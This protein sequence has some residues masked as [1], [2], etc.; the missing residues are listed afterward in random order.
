MK[1][2]K[3]IK[4]LLPTSIVVLTVLIVVA[5]MGNPPQ[6]KRSPKAA[7][8]KVLVE[9]QKIET[10]P[11]TVVIESY[12]TVKPRTKSTLTSQ[13]SGQI[14]YV[15][16]NFREG[17]FFKKGEVLIELDNRD[18]K[19]G[20]KVAEAALIL[21]QQT[22]SEESAKA[23]QAR[24]NWARL[25]KKG[26][27][28]D[29]VLRIP[30]LEAAKASV[31]SLEAQLSIAKLSLER[32]QIKTPFAG[33]ILNKSVDMGQVVSTNSSL[34]EIYATDVVEVRLPIKNRDLALV[35]LPE[36]IK[37]GEQIQDT[38]QVLLYSDLIGQQQWQG[39]I[40]RTEGAIDSTTQQLYAVAQIDR[41]FDQPS[42]LIKIGQYVNANIFGKTLPNAIRVPN[43]A[44]HQG[45]FVY[46]EKD[47]IIKRREIEILWQNQE[48]VLIK[49]GIESGENLVSSPLG[50]VVSGT[51]V[52]VINRASKGARN[53]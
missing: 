22:L 50:N 4:I 16:E 14:I 35:R 15:N 29:L 44:I 45:S 9:V 41:P 48:D 12:G 33:R 47:G 23:E 30:Q 52:K 42:P 49:H 34:A 21:A 11:Y 27:P 6:A 53:Q 8:S 38:T 5:L 36:E 43:S 32:T 25:G 2:K 51:A 46:I 24:E 20:V 17:G 19:A 3:M 28:N 1:F 39:Q 7:S 40:V 10:E 31:L 37:D 18:Y 26:K 13:V